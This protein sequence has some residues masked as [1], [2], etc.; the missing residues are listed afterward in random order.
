MS[1]DKIA[2]IANSLSLGGAERVSLILAEWM[3]SQGVDAFLF[4]LNKDREEGYVLGPSINR[5]AINN[6][7][8]PSK[9]KLIRELRK[10]LRKYGINKVLVMG[11]PLAVYAIPASAGLNISV[12]VSERNDPA[13]FKGRT[14]TKL[15]SRSLMLLAD[16]FIFQT[17]R[18][19]NYY[20]NVVQS[21]STVIPN[22]LLVD[23]L[24][25]PFNGVRSKR[26]VTAGRLVPQKNHELLIRVFKGIE[27]AYP[28]YTLTIYGNG[29]E[30][31]R[32]EKLIEGLNLENK[33]FLPGATKKLFKEIIDAEVFILSSDFEG[34][35]NALIEAMALGIPC[36]ST[37][38]PSGGPRELIKNMK[39]G[40]LVP[41]RNV[42]AMEDAIK[43]LIS[44]NAL[45][46][47]IG[48]NAV[49]IRSDL[50]IDTICQEWLEYLL[51]VGN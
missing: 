29:S 17:E 51:K 27:E 30:R 42:K 7:S 14:I 28:E 26:I 16:G 50:N 31:G 15:L 38:C 35:P 6:K 2:I 5:V 40:V 20:S 36:I 23:T 12:V 13:N 10:N 3:I 39:N 37:D 21:K 43:M 11:V 44:D 1:R 24:P 22:P 46:K 4:T 41:V 48:N 25:A 19:K 47:M 32:L 34:M 45:S 8:N 9:V 49:S 18:A 33:V